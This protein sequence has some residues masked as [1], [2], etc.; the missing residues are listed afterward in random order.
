MFGGLSV[1]L[2]KP[3][4][5]RIDKKRLGNA[6]FEPLPQNPSTQTPEDE[7]LQDAREESL[8]QNKGARVSV[9]HVEA[10]DAVGPVHR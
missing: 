8:S 4:R 7:Y 6:H 9:A 10:T 3:W 2:Y 1:I 5:R